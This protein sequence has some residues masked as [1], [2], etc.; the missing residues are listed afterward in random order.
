MFNRIQK[1]V[2]T[3]STTGQQIMQQQAQ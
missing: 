2:G 1:Q 3:H